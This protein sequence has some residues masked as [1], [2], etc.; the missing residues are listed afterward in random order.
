[1]KRTTGTWFIAVVFAL[2]AVFL[3]PQQALAGTGDAQ[4]AAPAAAPSSPSALTLSAQVSPDMPLQQTGMGKTW[5]TVEWGIPAVDGKPDA[6]ITRYKVEWGEKKYTKHKW[7]KDSTHKL[8]ITGLSPN[9]TYK[10]RISY[11]YWYETPESWIEAKWQECTA[12]TFTTGTE[13]TSGWKYNHFIN[14]GLNMDIAAAQIPQGHGGYETVV[15]AGSKIYS[16][17]KKQKR[18]EQ[19]G[20]NAWDGKLNVSAGS[21]VLSAKGA[22]A[23]VAVRP[24]M[25]AA[26]T[27]V[28]YGAWK[29][30]TLVADTTFNM[31]WWTGDS[32]DY[33]MKV[34]ID[35]LKNVQSYTVCMGK[36]TGKKADGTYKVKKWTKAATVAADSNRKVSVIIS[37]LGGKKLPSRNHRYAVKVVTN[38][39]YG[40]SQGNWQITW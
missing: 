10:V 13:G 18:S 6:T 34:T 1:M 33:K 23:T 17:K 11:R 14:G 36:I 19:Y 5:V 15:V 16:D 2:C 12:M 9:T 30:K 31:D 38:T 20:V 21:D 3:V 8:K 24:Y 37:K 26:G 7:V 25:V 27:G 35:P 22:L 28:V 4:A 40:N 32:G 39:K 29:K